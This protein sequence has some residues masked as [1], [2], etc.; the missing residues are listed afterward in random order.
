RPRLHGNGESSA[1]VRLR[2]RMLGIPFE[3]LLYGV[4]IL[5]V[6][7]CWWLVQHQAMVGWALG[8]TGLILLGYVG[9]VA[10]TRLD[11][12]ARNRIF[13]AGLLMIGSVLFWALFGHA[14]AAAN[15]VADAYV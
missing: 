14:G 6:V 9:W 1:P 7:A 5:I 8:I 13:A 3:W 15:H 11:A 2:E 12:H 10:S 4:G